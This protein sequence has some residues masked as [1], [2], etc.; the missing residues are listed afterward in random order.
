MTVSLAP[1]VNPK[2]AA[3]RSAR[4]EKTSELGKEKKNA[5]YRPVQGQGSC[6]HK[7]KKIMS[8]D[9]QSKIIHEAI[10]V[11]QGL[12]TDLVLPSKIDQI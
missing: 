10:S 3:E 5:G 7:K 12:A 9:M 8:W 11:A 4:G 2:Q 6:C 1:Q